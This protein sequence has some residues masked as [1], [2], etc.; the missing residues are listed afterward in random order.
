L[1]MPITVI[2]GNQDEDVDPRTLEFARQVLAPGRLRLL[3]V[4]GADHRLPWTHHQMLAGA[5]AAALRRS[6][7]AS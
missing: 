2:Q 4:R 6:E 3:W 7:A 1:H 5:I